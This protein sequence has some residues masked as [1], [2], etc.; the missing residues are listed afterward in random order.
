VNPG[1]CGAGGEV[2][3]SA[4]GDGHRDADAV[5]GDVDEQ[6]GA[7]G[8]G[9]FG[10]VGVGVPHGVADR[11]PQH[12]L[13]VD[14]QVGGDDVDAAGDADRG[15][16][17]GAGG[18]L[19]DD[20]MQQA[21]QSS[22]A[23]RFGVQVDARGAD[24]GDDLVEVLDVLGDPRGHRRG[25]G[26]VL[27]VVQGQADPGQPPDDVLVQVPGDPVPAGEHQQFALRRKAFGALHRQ[28]GLGRRRWTPAPGHPHR[29]RVSRQ[30]AP[31]AAP[32]TVRRR[33]PAARPAPVP[34]TAPARRRRRRP[35][36]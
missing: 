7:D 26:H 33:R 8:D 32:R 1:R 23:G 15:A 19:A 3:Q 14:G 25:V 34:S 36:R 6:L 24:L 27:G 30:Y 5:V 31:R 18:D 9:E 28:R 17:V 22:G 16:Q 4:A 11:F 35:G 12:R 13:G 2:V 29:K 10:G 21:T 20:V